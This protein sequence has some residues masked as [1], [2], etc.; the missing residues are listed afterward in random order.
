M[1]FS[2]S[3][4]VFCRFEEILPYLEAD[5]QLRGTMNGILLMAKQLL[6][7]VS[8]V[9]LTL[10]GIVEGTPQIMQLLDVA[11]NNSHDALGF[12]LHVPLRNPEKLAQIFAASDPFEY[13]CNH[14]SS[15]LQDIFSIPSSINAEK[16]HNAICSVNQSILDELYSLS[17]WILLESEMQNTKS[18]TWQEIFLNIEGL[19]QEITILLE[20]LPK[21]FQDPVIKLTT[22]EEIISSFYKDVNITSD[23]DVFEL[24][25]T[26]N[27][28]LSS[29]YGH[30]AENMTEIYFEMFTVYVNYANSMFNKIR[31]GNRELQLG[32]LFENTT[33]WKNVMQF[34][35]SLQ[36][37]AMDAILGSTIRVVKVNYV[38]IVR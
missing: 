20:N 22:L 17:G 9:N 32:S 29:V 28:V 27:S 26:F 38:S 37:N 35:F 36:E 31:T 34:M 10:N 1:R 6:G 33:L 4:I 2:H 24:L 23:K 21:N 14:T 16:V 8:N 18:T 30:A 11:F 25:G 13:L 12:L 5:E 19:S 7:T 3:K 15:A